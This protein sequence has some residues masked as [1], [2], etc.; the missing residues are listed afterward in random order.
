MVGTLAVLVVLIGSG[1]Y[2]TWRLSAERNQAQREAEK[3]EQVSQFL[4]DLFQEADPSRAT[5]DTI[6]A[7]DLLRE[8]MEQIGELGDQ[9]AVQAELMHVIGST[10]RTRPG[11]GAVSSYSCGPLKR[12]TRRYADEG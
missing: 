3:A 10:H 2:H 4:A 1:L 5:G 8:G 6:T 11:R 7:R 9:P 12:P